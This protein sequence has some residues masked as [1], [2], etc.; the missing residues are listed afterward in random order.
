M[1]R[2]RCVR[3]AQDALLQGSIMAIELGR[4][5]RHLPACR[6]IA[7]PVAP[8]ARLDH[9]RRADA[10][11]ICNSRSTLPITRKH[12]IP[13]ILGVSLPPTPPHLTLRFCPET[14]ESHH[15]PAPEPPFSTIPV[16][17]ETL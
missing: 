17:Q 4:R 3:A 1:L 7:K 10:K 8:L 16:R 2:E 15:H 12:P 5:V 14:Y 9:I 11:P 6:H 13:Q